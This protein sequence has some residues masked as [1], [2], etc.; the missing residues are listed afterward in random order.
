MALKAIGVLLARKHPTGYIVLQRVLFFGLI[1]FL[2]EDR[3]SV[4]DC[5]YP[6]RKDVLQPLPS[7][8]SRLRQ[9]LPERWRRLIQTKFS[10]KPGQ[11]N[12]NWETSD[13]RWV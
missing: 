7:M 11:Y 1:S 13:V 5:R 6:E 3:H 12:K 9:S 4:M 8:A 10:N 2:N